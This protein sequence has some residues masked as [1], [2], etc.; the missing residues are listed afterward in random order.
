MYFYLKNQKTLTTK[1]GNIYFASDFHLGYPDL[2]HSREREFL[3][4][5]WL[6]SIKNTT[7]ELYLVGDIFDFWYEYKWVVPKGYIRF[8][9]KIA[10]FTDSGIPVHMFKGNHDTWI[11]DYLPD[12][13]GVIVH[14]EEPLIKEYN[15]KRFYIH[16]GDAL[17]SFDKG[18]NFLKVIFTNKSLQWMFSRVHPNA[19]FGF[20]H[21]WSSHNREKKVYESAN[22]LGDEK[23]WL[24][25]H[26]KNVLKQEHFDYFVYGHRHVA[27]DKALREDSRYINLG[28]WITN[29]SYAVFNG[30]DVELKQFKP[31][32]IPGSKILLER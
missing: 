2:K 26:S 30:N 3:L 24:L 25:Q 28:N 17:G 15:G 21:R 20:A 31:E 19:A 13:I 8:L 4:I 6:D 12:E 9:A 14:D 16:H 5:E 11:K 32:Q 18:M 10:E 22:Y 7:A 23:E 27:I 1:R 29:T